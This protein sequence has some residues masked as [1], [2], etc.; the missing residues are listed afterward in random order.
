MRS[1]THTIDR[2][3]SVGPNIV[4]AWFDT[5]LNPLLY[6]LSVEHNVLTSG[7]WTWRFRPPRL[8]SLVPVRA[9]VV[10][11]A[12]DNLE[13]FLAFHPEC[14]R[15]IEEHDRR[16]ESLFSACQLFHKALTNSAAFKE[17]Y[18]RTTAQVPLAPGSSVSDLFGATLPEDHLDVIA[19]YVVNNAGKLPSY[20]KTAPLWNQYG[21]EFVRV[22]ESDAVRPHWEESQNAGAQLADAVD[23]LATAIRAARQELSL[24]YDVPF[25]Y[26]I[27]PVK[28][29]QL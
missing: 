13:Q 16:V 29:R 5:V 22:R 3:K 10:A 26:Q 18:D 11:E 27:S 9:H 21:A 17:A 28:Y 20:Y 24:E 25:V 2:G 6:G 19:E 15:P 4:R 8:L 7:D 23:E 14:R 1:K 12:R